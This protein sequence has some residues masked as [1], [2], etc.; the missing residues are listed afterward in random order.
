ML[1]YYKRTWDRLS[2]SYR[3]FTSELNW[4]FGVCHTTLSDLAKILSKNVAFTDNAYIFKTAGKMELQNLG[5]Y[6]TEFQLEKVATCQ[7]FQWNPEI[8]EATLFYTKF[9]RSE[10]LAILN[11]FK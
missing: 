6:S 9:L 8:N 3:I 7:L 5:I 4:A 11:F 10:K 1:D 2:I